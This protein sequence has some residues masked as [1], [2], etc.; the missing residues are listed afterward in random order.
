MH[1]AAP[2]LAPR[3]AVRT[4]GR[5]GEDGMDPSMRTETNSR[6]VRTTGAFTSILSAAPSDRNSPASPA[7]TVRTS[8]S[9]KRQTTVATG[10][11]PANP[12]RALCASAA[13]DQAFYRP[14]ANRRARDARPFGRTSRAPRYRG[15]ALVRDPQV[16]RTDSTLPGRTV[17]YDSP[18][19]QANPVGQSGGVER[20]RRRARPLTARIAGEARKAGRA[21][22]EALP[23]RG[24]AG[25]AGRGGGRGVLLLF[26]L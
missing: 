10:D 25:G 19:W 14:P 12:D 4:A 5:R 3:P 15:L 9:R 26:N 16:V 2:L 13:R 6:D 11:Q 7:A 17:I 1:R 22:Q 18:A 24:R 20:R 8:P 21:L 23:T